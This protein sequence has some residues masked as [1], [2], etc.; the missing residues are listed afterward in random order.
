MALGFSSISNLPSVFFDGEYRVL[1]LTPSSEESK[2]KFPKFGAHFATLDP[3]QWKE[4]DLSSFNPDVLDQDG[5]G[6][7]ASFA[8]SGGIAMGLL[9]AGR[10]KKAF[11]PYFLYALVNG[12][13]DAGSSLSDVMSALMVDGVCS[14]EMMPYRLTFKSQLPQQAYDDA[15]KYKLLKTFHC[16]SF[17][18]ICSAITLG[19]TVPLGIMVGNNF[20][21]LDNEGVAPLPSGGG[22]GHAILGIGL[23]Q[24]SRYGWVIK[25][26]NS[27][28]SSFGMRGYC[29]LRKEMFRAMNPD[30]FAIQSVNDPDSNVPVVTN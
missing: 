4:T 26:L 13:R 11:N 8:G 12:G 16:G 27:W 17:E 25:I 21:N 23:H 20:S 24:S 14:A 19:F 18:E 15:S 29:Y 2:A 30:A 6:A 28:G 9:Q 5:V 22:G 3:S 10:P 1:G 7:C